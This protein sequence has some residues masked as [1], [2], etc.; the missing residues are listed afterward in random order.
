MYLKFAPV[1]AMSFLRTL[2]V[3]FTISLPSKT[4][5]NKS[6]VVIVLY[7]FS[8]GLKYENETFGILYLPLNCGTTVYKS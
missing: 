5:T 6:S 1:I 4:F 3:V 2:L 7:A 8:F